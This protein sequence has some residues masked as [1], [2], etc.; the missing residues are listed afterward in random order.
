M[1][2]SF[3]GITL[4]TLEAYGVQTMPYEPQRSLDLLLLCSSK[5]VYPS[6][7][8]SIHGDWP[9]SLRRVIIIVVII[10]IIIVIIVIIIVIII[11]I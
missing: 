11:I 2:C 9:T 5:P 8:P 10:I 1:E 3:L 7:H 4:L 6:I